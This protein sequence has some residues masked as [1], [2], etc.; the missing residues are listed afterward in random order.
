MNSRK[1]PGRV[2]GMGGGTTG[3]NNADGRGPKSPDAGGAAQ[4]K[5]AADGAGAPERKAM[6]D[7]HGQSAGGAA[8]AQRPQ[9]APP[10]VDHLPPFKVLL[11]NDD[12]HDMMFV[13]EAIVDLTP[14]RAEAAAKVMLEAHQTGLGLLLV[15][16][17]ERAE[18]YA[19][20]FRSKGLVVTIEAV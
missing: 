10:R 14:L 7:D 4:P 3:N 2:T 8:T 9:T 1:R 20:Q 5:G 19:E 13:V 12:V 15:T 6:N 16:H 17:K 18:L 11:H